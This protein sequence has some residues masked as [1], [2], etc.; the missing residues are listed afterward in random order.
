MSNVAGGVAVSGAR[1]KAPTDTYKV[2]ATY[3]DGFKAT[4]VA[5]V[6]GGRAAE[7]GRKT[8]GAILKRARGILAAKGMDDF[9]RS[10]ISVIGAEDNFGKNAMD[11][12]RDSPKLLNVA[13]W[14]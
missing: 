8:A 14:Q 5:V 11:Q 13:A 6:A 9:S 1:G 10:H 3:L 4:G 2:S 12:G 7:K